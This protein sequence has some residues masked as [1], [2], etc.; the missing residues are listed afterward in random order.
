MSEA[1]KTVIWA[2]EAR[3]Q[4]RAIDLDNALQILHAVAITSQRVSAR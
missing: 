1:R 2:P 3:E 4:L